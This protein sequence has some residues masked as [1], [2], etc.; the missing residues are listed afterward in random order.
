MIN[1]TLSCPACDIRKICR[2]LLTAALRKLTHKIS[3]VFF[4]LIRLPSVDL[5]F[6]NKEYVILLVYFEIENYALL[7]FS[8]AKLSL[9]LLMPS[10]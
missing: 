3:H 8:W 7:E 5:I 2:A 1:S 4:K 9:Y 6:R 10:E